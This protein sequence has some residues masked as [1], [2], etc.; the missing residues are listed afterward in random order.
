MVL[1]PAQVTVLTGRNGAGKTTALQVIAGLIAPSTGKVTVAGIDIAELEP[2]SWWRQLSW[3]PQRPVLLPGTVVD[4]LNL[5]GEL[6]DPDTVCRAVQFDSVVA[7]LPDGLQTVLG[8]DGVGLSLGERQ[9]LALARALGS[10]APVLLLDE[11]TAHLDADSE[12]RVL[13][14]VVERARAGAT[15]VVVAHREQVV[16]IGDQVVE[17]RAERHAYV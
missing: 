1:E 11:P 5:F 15:V 10:P 6:T 3:L 17:V 4:N 8:R 13:R 14:A 9:R 16:A 12:A 2:A 7:K